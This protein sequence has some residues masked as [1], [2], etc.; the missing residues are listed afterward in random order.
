MHQP[1]NHISQQLL[2]TVK[3][4]KNI[5][6]F[7][8][9]GVSAESGVPTFRGEGG[10]WKKMKA[11]ELANFDAFLRNPSLVW[12][13][14]FERKKIISTIQPNAGHFAIAQMENLFP[15]VIVVTQNIDGLHRRAGSKNVLELHGNIERNYCI[16][17]KTQY[18]NEILFSTFIENEQLKSPPKCFECGGLI[19]PDVVWFGEQLPVQVWDAAV[20]AIKHCE[21]FFSVGTSAVVYPAASLIELARHYSAYIVEINVEAT[22]ATA[23]VDEHIAEK[24]A[25]VF[26]Q[27]LTLL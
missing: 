24:S 4:A 27:L 3:K 18:T 6:I 9:A 22:P 11:E 20:N 15:K 16:K 23:F 5:V 26:T 13:W 25:D 14:Y 10:I 19:R 21:L 12:E 7:S 2:K 1:I 8:G 17:C